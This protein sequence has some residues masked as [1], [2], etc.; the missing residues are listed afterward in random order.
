MRFLNIPVLAQSVLAV[1]AT[2]V[3]SESAFSIAGNI[4]TA[5]RGTLTDE[6][7]SASILIKSWKK[8]LE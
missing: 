7:I 6:S 2:S 3:C 1:Q 8:V 5:R 4:V